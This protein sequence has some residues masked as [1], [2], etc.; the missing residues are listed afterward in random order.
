MVMRLKR[1][2]K[3]EEEDGTDES[4]YGVISC[5][6]CYTIIQQ[7]MLLHLFLPPKLQLGQAVPSSLQ[8]QEI[9]QHDLDIKTIKPLTPVKGIS[10][11][12]GKV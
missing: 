12:F 10:P 7:H 9:I 4:G 5:M 8:P 2:E 6:M 3:K 1:R 11:E